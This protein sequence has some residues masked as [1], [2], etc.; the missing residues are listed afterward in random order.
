[1]TKPM[2]MP[3]WAVIVPAS[4]PWLRRRSK[5][6]R[7]R[8]L[9]MDADDLADL[10]QEYPWRVVNGTGTHAAV[11]DFTPEGDWD[12]EL[13][14]ALSAEVKGTVFVANLHESARGAV[15]FDG[16]S[17]VG[18]MS[19]S[20]EELAERLGCAFPEAAG[21]TA[22]TRRVCVVEGASPADVDA[23]LVLSARERRLVRIESHPLG[24]IVYR[25]DGDDVAGVAYA[26]CGN[27]L[28]RA[29]AYGIEVGDGA[30]S[31]VVR[32]FE[33]GEMVGFFASD[34]SMGLPPRKVPRVYEIKGESD[35]RKILA[36]LHVG[37]G[38]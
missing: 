24:T 27:D 34:A 10:E 15:A 17:C 25:T 11:W 26:I 37:A 2:R 32:V 20:P 14:A 38:E 6:L 35:P 5:E 12:G 33:D 18:P 3:T 16:G 1:M 31:L 9:G 29:T 21:P 30:A 36:A 13:A 23:A 8:L 4:A 28:S 7:M 22:D 19:E